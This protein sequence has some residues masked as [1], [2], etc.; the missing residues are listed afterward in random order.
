MELNVWE[1]HCGL[2][3]LVNVMKRILPEGDRFRTLKTIR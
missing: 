1:D 2:G 3:E